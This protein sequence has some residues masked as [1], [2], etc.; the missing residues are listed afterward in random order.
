VRTFASYTAY[1]RQCAAR[2]SP[3]TSTREHVQRYAESTLGMSGEARRRRGSQH[4]V[5]LACN[6]RPLS[7]Q[8]LAQLRYDLPASYAFHRSATK[9]VEVDLWRFARRASGSAA[10]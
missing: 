6:S 10:P 9:D 4:C 1:C 5:K 7:P 3:Q 2:A 8:V